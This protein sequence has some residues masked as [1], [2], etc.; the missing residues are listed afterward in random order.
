MK[1]QE[2]ISILKDRKAYYN[3]HHA[4]YDRVIRYLEGRERRKKDKGDIGEREKL[5]VNEFNDLID[6]LDN[7]RI[8]YFNRCTFFLESIAE[9][10]EQIHEYKEK[11]N[12]E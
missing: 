8:V 3:M 5:I 6:S 12:D 7:L 11:W 4:G 10:E 2:A 1:E 9:L